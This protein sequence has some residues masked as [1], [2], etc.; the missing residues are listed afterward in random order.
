MNNIIK[1]ARKLI[2]EMEEDNKREITIYKMIK[3][4]YRDYGQ[5][6]GD[7]LISVIK[8]Q[9][10]KEYGGKHVTDTATPGEFVMEMMG[11]GESIEDIGDSLINS[12]LL[13]QVLQNT[14][15]SDFNEP[16][17]YARAV[18][19]ALVTAAEYEGMAESDELVS[20]LEE[21]Y[22]EDL[23]NLYNSGEDVE[24]DGDDDSSMIR[25]DEYGDEDTDYLM[26]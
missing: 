9:L 17:E 3:K 2:R 22:M 23:I 6:Q 20:Y 24:N 8:K 13:D 25:D 7:K 19:E 5:E 26:P 16:V 15:A 18:I 21:V 14:Y 1:S 11:P 12:E 4:Y 10:S